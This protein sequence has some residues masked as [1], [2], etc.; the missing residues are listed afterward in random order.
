M[1]HFYRMK[2]LLKIEKS[3]RQKYAN[4]KRLMLNKGM[5][6][7]ETELLRQ[8]EKRNSID[9]NIKKLESIINET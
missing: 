5:D 9:I 4:F 6:K 1:H 7:L 3:T 2:E 8:R